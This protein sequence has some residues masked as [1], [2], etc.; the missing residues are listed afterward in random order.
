MPVLGHLGSIPI[1]AFGL[2]V[3]LAFISA[4]VLMHRDFARKG[5][6]TDLAW[7]IV[8]FALVGGLL[9]ARLNLAIEH[10]KA[11]LAAPVSFLF[12]R[13]GF[14]WY[15]GVAGGVIAT[16]W[17]IRH[18]RVSWASAADTAAPALAL[19]LA[20]GRIGCHLAGDGDWGTPSRLPWAVS[21]A[22]GTAPWPHP[23]GVRVHPAALYEALA[24]AALFAVLWCLRGRIGP[25]GT[26]FAIYL[27]AAGAIRFL[28]ELARTNRPIALGLTEAQWIS[29][30]VAGGAAVWLGSLARRSERHGER[31]GRAPA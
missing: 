11:F 24:L 25:K 6:P 31:G 1:H 21:Y 30:A 4:G 28:V 3:S 14:V 15:G 13:S 20:V 2:M 7:A 8:A 19:G 23:P 29:L 12:A 16:L 27:V 9:G 22:N 10:P 17:P 26:T 18:W 5:E